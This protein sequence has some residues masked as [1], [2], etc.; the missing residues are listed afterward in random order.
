MGII[1]LSASLLA[2]AQMLFLYY[3]PEKTVSPAETFPLELHF[4][5]VGQGDSALVLCG[6]E[7]LLIDT[8]TAETAEHLV[9]AL[10]AS[11]VSHLDYLLCTHD[12]ADHIGGVTAVL[13]AISVDFL[14]FSD[15]SDPAEWKALLTGH[16][17]APASLSV[18][19]GF[20]LGVAESAG[21]T[22]PEAAQI[23]V[24][25]PATASEDENEGS[26]VIQITFGEISALFM[27]D[28]GTS[29]E[30]TLLDA[31]YLSDIDILKVGHHGS[32]GSTGDAFLSRVRPEYAVISAG[33]HN[34]YGHPHDELL[35]R[36]RL[37]GAAVF[38]TDLQGDIVL[39]SDGQT[40]TVKTA[41]NENADTLELT[42]PA[43]YQEI[44]QYVINRKSNVFHDPDCNGA[45]S[46]KAENRLERESSHLQL[47]EEG[48]RPCG[49]C[50]P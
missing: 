30:E 13:D 38:R 9:S 41:G 43:K 36:L 33:L 47:V 8:G 35:E 21:L 7:A 18:G 27:G 6:G 5:D 1:L 34:D 2:L 15:T 37:S 48:Y 14:L 12:H 46:L 17:T 23:A 24:L 50:D 49:L 3:A 16:D 44:R 45:K 32:S 19:T 31:G 29:T 40:V 26:L 11:G 10:Q 39:G 4:F 22:P 28:V 20:S 25:S 42:P